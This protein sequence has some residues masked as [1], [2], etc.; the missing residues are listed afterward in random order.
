MVPHSASVR[1][2]TKLSPLAEKV[3]VLR[4]HTQLEECACMINIEVPLLVIIYRDIMLLLLEVSLSVKCLE[5]RSVLK[6][7]RC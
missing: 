5:Q 7:H 2:G 1:G 6:I 3:L 4:L